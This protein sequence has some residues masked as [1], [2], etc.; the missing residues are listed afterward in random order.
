[1]KEEQKGKTL[2]EHL[3]AEYHTC[4]QT[5]KTKLPPS[6]ASQ[7]AEIAA[8]TLVYQQL[9]EGGWSREF[10]DYMRRFENPLEMVQ[11]LCLQEQDGSHTEGYEGVTVRGF[12]EKHP[13]SPVSMMTPGGYVNLVTGQAEKLLAGES[14]KGNPGCPGADIDIPAEELLEQIICDCYPADGVWYMM[15]DIAEISQENGMEAGRC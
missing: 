15:T 5:L 7:T 11:D 13:D 6:L 14:M 10:W 1:M 2:K 9:H 12:L 8:A 4:F 3:R